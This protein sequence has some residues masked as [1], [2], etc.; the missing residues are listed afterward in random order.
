MGI[1]S[2]VI[3]A[4]P[5]AARFLIGNSGAIGDVVK[6]VRDVT[7]LE[8]F[9]D[10]DEFSIVP[11]PGLFAPSVSVVSLEKDLR[12]ANARL[13]T[14]AKKGLTPPKQ[15]N[16]RETKSVKVDNLFWT[17]PSHPV[18]SHDGIPSAEMYRDLAL[19]LREKGFPLFFKER[20]GDAVDVAYRL[21]QGLFANA[22]EKGIAILIKD[23]QYIHKLPVSIESGDKSCIIN[24]QHVYYKIPMGKTG[25]EDA[26]Q[27]AL[28]M[29]KSLTDDFRQQYELEQADL[30][31]LSNKK[32]P[33]GPVW[34][35]TCEINWRTVLKANNAGKSLGPKLEE[36]HGY[37]V[38]FTNIEANL[39]IVKI[40][41]RANV[42]P[43]QVRANIEVLAG[44]LSNNVSNPNLRLLDKVTEPLSA[45]GPDVNIVNAAYSGDY[46]ETGDYQMAIRRQAAETA[47]RE[48]RN[49]REIDDMTARIL[50]GKDDMATRR[51]A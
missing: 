20:N 29:N 23:D 17:V 27:A 8:A 24:T 15:D 34:I 1:A 12:K 51:K 40:V 6:A 41:T 48:A 4:I 26:W 7:G 31:F 13:D 16:D 32:P 28:H 33:T 36:D 49:Q 38:P 9:E 5:T 3:S 30:V 47:R 39:Q 19:I 37:Y 35:L 42:A 10:E 45:Q 11:K 14:E 22:K 50:A 25:T 43:A 44:K 46:R 18:G 2:S 21:A